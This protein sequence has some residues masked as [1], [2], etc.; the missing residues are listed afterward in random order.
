VKYLTLAGEEAAEMAAAEE[1]AAYYERAAEVG[2][3][4]SMDAA[5]L[6][7]LYVRAAE[8]HVSG[9]DIARSPEAIERA[10]AF[11]EMAPDPGRENRLAVARAY[12]RMLDA[13]AL[14]DDEIF[15]AIE[16][17]ERRGDHAGAARAWLALE[18]I[19]CGRSNRFESG[20]AAERMLEC[21]RLAGS[22]QLIGN[23]MRY[24][25]GTA[26][27]GAGTTSEG[28]RRLRALYPDAPD[29]LTRAR[30][31][32]SIGFLEGCRRRFDE[33]RAL[34]V[35]AVGLAVGHRDR[36]EI[37]A[38]MWTRSAHLE[39]IA[40]NYA[41]AEEAGRLAVA[42][43][44]RQGLI[45]YLS[46][47]LMLLAD[48]LILQGKLDEAEFH[49]DRAAPMAAPDDADALLR[50]AR[51]RGRLE[52]ARGH[53]EA[54]ERHLRVALSHVEAAE[55]PD[56]HADT[57]LDLTRILHAQGREGE[58]REAATE[59]ARVADERENLV[60]A[61]RAREFLASSA[62]VVLAD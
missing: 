60:F 38:Y 62:P 14:E 25:A 5:T 10:E 16:F 3:A 40:G 54:A 43:L 1:A 26:A 56:E 31:L 30:I 20:Q 18:F 9:L 12:G 57:L 48:A 6:C 4:N 41:R 34:L 47:E 49:I 23:A 22:R 42:D 46:S 50:Q 37:E 39:T 13:F 52:F 27:L 7:E 45:R 8:Q 32:I 28:I 17:F 15:D 21:A 33:G 55:A 44:E 36:A 11:L 29:A 59:A 19:N 61:D 24:I 35:Q 53:L 2:Q 58:A 51:S